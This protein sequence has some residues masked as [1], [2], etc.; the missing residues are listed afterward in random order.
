MRPKC[1]LKVMT[2]KELLIMAGIDPANEWTFT[3]NTRREFQLKVVVRGIDLY[4]A[5]NNAIHKHGIKYRAI[6]GI[7]LQ[8]DV[9]PY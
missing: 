2:G 6:T 4:D 5:I 1:T 7:K 8:D 3:Y 9:A